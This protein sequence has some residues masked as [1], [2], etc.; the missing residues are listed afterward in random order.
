[1]GC[2]SSRGSAAECFPNAHGNVTACGGAALSSHQDKVTFNLQ[3]NGLISR[4]NFCNSRL[5]GSYGGARPRWPVFV[6]LITALS[7]VVAPRLGIGFHVSRS[8][9]AGPIGSFPTPRLQGTLIG[10]CSP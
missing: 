1:M 4:A 9:R 7:A 3:R 8:A 2:A 10:V 5:R 6:A